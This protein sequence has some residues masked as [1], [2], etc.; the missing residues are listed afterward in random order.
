MLELIVSLIFIL[1]AYR[2]FAKRRKD[3]PHRA[4][5]RP[6]QSFEVTYHGR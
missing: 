6:L 2:L 3:K 5:M 4:R 1:I